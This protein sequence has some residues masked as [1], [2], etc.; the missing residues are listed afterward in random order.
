MYFKE[1]VIE[2][3]WVCG[4]CEKKAHNVKRKLRIS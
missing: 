1:E 3:D 4:E 2:G